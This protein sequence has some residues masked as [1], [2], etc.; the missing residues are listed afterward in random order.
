M[1][2]T[3][4][5]GLE[6]AGFPQGSKGTWAYPPDAIVGRAK[7]RVYVPTLAELIEAC[8]DRFSGLTRDA[9]PSPWKWIAH[10]TDGA[11]VD[12]RGG[13]AEEAVA[14]L[15]LGLNKKKAW[16]QQWRGGVF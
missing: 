13:T 15:W 12:A 14:R 11:T 7:D 3:L 4:A 10:G 2:Y 6:Q 9:H 1:D 8:G 5:K 16:F